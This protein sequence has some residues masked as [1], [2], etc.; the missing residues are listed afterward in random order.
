MVYS[1]KFEGGRPLFV[2]VDE[3]L[4]F[5]RRNSPLLYRD[6]SDRIEKDDLSLKLAQGSPPEVPRLPNRRMYRIR[7]AADVLRISRSKV[8]QL[9]NA[10]RLRRVKID[11]CSLIDGEDVEALLS[12]V[13]AMSRN[14]D[15]GLEG[16]DGKKVGRDPRSMSCQELEELGHKP[17]SPGQ[18]LRA[19]C[20]D[21]C[22]GSEPEVGWCTA[23]LCPSWPFRMGTSPW[24]KSFSDEQL[25][26]A[27][28]R[29][30]KLNEA[31]ERARQKSSTGVVEEVPESDGRVL[32]A[33]P[34]ANYKKRHP[35][36]A[37]APSKTT[38]SARQAVAK[39]DSGAT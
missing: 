18:A 8:Y 35:E 19:R 33:A 30:G 12:G 14:R 5:H 11:R 36:Q 20:V 24:K 6:R 28:A 38:G 22:G 16:P 21:C 39:E 34:G 10:G 13:P 17:M 1:L 4:H 25:A 32:R 7:E 15:V 26:A 27:R 31:R 9:I 2:A 3:Q 29:A 37:E 23:V